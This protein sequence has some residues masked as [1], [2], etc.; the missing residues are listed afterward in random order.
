M[1]A[2]GIAKLGVAVDHELERLA[3]HRGRLLRDV[4]EHPARRHLNL[5]GIRVQLAANEREKARLPAAVRADE[6]DL[7]ARMH[8]HR[9]RG[10]EH[11]R[12]PS[13]REI[14]YAQHDAESRLETEWGLS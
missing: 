12:P 2:L 13:Q 8:G 5:T 3:R 14:A 10:E 1:A 7:L 6:P 4:G 9:R 11:P